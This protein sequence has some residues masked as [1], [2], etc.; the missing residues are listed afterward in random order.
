MNIGIIE[1][2]IEIFLQQK[3]IKSFKAIFKFENS[4]KIYHDRE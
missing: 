2:Y 1:N 3:S 4:K